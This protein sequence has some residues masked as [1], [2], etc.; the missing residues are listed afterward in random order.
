MIVSFEKDPAQSGS[1]H[2]ATDESHVIL[3]PVASCISICTGTGSPQTR[4]ALSRMTAI[5]AVS[6][7]VISLV[8]FIVSSILALIFNTHGESDQINTGICDS[9]IS[10][11]I[12]DFL[13]PLESTIY[14]P[15]ISNLSECTSGLVGLPRRSKRRTMARVLV[16]FTSADDIGTIRI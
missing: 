11:L 1:F 9:M 10:I 13:S 2:D 7:I 8:V 4:G 15:V 16:P 6:Y 14:Q 12:D 5:R 3:F